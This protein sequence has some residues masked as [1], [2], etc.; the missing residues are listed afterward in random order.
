MRDNEKGN[1]V[2][3]KGDLSYETLKE[4]GRIGREN[5]IAQS[6]RRA[7]TAKRLKHI[8][9]ANKM[10]QKTLCEKIG[11]LIT[12]YS[13]Y[14]QG[15]HDIPTEAIARI[16]ELFDVSAD[17]IIGMTENTKGKYAEEVERQMAEKEN[18]INHKVDVLTKLIDN[19]EGQST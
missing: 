4:V 6:K 2:S 14:E 9:T 1:L 18:E 16:A 19:I 15:K 12:T 8:R 3:E 11:I 17:Y 10:T 5:S 13:G 7:I